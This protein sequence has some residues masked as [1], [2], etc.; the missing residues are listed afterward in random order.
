MKRYIKSNKF[1]NLSSI[2]AKHMRY[3]EQAAKIIA[4]S[5]LFD[6]NTSRNII[7]AL[8]DGD[9]HAFVRCPPWLEKY[10]K[11]I[12]RMLV[13]EAHGSIQGAVRFLETSPAIFDTYLTFV[14]ELR[15]K[16]GGVEYDN[17]FLNEMKYSDV[18][19][20][21]EK[22]IDTYYDDNYDL[23][24]TTYPGEYE[25]IPIYDYDQL[26]SEFGGNW[27]GDGNSSD[28][29]WCHTNDRSV[30]D[31]WTRGGQRLFVL[32]RNDWKDIPFNPETNAQTPKDEYGT[33]L[34]AIRVGKNGQLLNATLRCNHIGTPKAPDRQY[35]TFAQLS[36][37]TGMDVRFAVE[38]Y[39]ID[40]M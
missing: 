16:L 1:S 12:A 32:A 25:L 21:I 36:E 24:E 29:T 18:E 31:A 33:S 28:S 30:Y 8:F 38:R 35:Q 7:N 2:F 39:I 19:D 3:D 20:E 9:I 23:P 11:G 34:I 14:T 17:Y 22:F 6:I 40:D 15:D 4:D 26:H 5:G 10:L 13:E 27:T 37:L